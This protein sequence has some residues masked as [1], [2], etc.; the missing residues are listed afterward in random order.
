MYSLSHS[1]L[2]PQPLP[3]PY[4]LELARLEEESP[5]VLPEPP[6]ATPEPKPDLE[7]WENEGGAWWV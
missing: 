2:T 1:C 5:L 4:D 6:S 7:R 3:Q